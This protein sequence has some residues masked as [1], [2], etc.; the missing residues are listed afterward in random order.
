MLSPHH[1][2][3]P[4]T[5]TYPHIPILWSHVVSGPHII[6][7]IPTL[8]T[9]SPNHPHA[10][11]CP[12]HNLTYPHIPILWSPCCLWSSH[13]PCHPHIVNMVPKSSSCPH[14]PTPHPH[15]PPHTHPVVPMLSLV[16]TSSLSS[17]H[18]QHGPQIILMPPYA[19]PTQPQYGGSR[20]SKNSIRLEVIEI[21]PF[22]LKI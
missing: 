13:H 6:P 8:S 14:M 10:P 18:C 11:I 5:L 1:P 3:H 19:H 20:I 17:P 21:L 16:L 7:V 9:W 22:F 15:I 4:H 2:C 12:P